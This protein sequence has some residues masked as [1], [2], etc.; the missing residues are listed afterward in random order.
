MLAG[1]VREN[2]LL[3]APE[4]PEAELWFGAHH[5]APST[6]AGRPL[7][8]VIAEDPQAALGER[9]AAAGGGE[10]PFLVKLLAAGAPL[11]IQV[12]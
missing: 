9:V 4:T 8:A 7:D 3:A 1:T 5:A 10:L 6:L 2:L 11:S 12:C